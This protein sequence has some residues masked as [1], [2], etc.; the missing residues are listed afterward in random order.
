MKRDYIGEYRILD[1]LGHGGMG[2]VYK[3]IDERLKRTVAIKVIH[4]IYKKF[5]VREAI[6]LGQLDHPN[7]V[8]VYYAGDVD[9]D[10]FIVMEYVEG[11]TLDH[12]GVIPLSTCISYLKQTLDAVEYAHGKGIIHRDIK[13]SN[14]MV[15]SDGV[16]KV[17]DFGL[18]RV[19]LDGNQTITSGIVAGT[20]MYMSPE[21]VRGLSTLDHRTDIYSLGKT[22]YALVAGRLP[23]KTGNSSQYEIQRQIVEGNFKP[24]STFNAALPAEV[25][26]L[27][28]K[29]IATEPSHRYQSV[30]E[31]KEALL[32]LEKKLELHKSSKKRWV[33]KIASTPTAKLVLSVLIVVCICVGA[34]WIWSNNSESTEPVGAEK[35][36]LVLRVTPFADSI[37]VDGDLLR[38]VPGDT[39]LLEPGEHRIEMYAGGFHTRDTVVT[40]TAGSIKTI[41]AALA[42]L[43]QQEI[44]EM[45]VIRTSPASATVTIDG[46]VVGQSPVDIL[47]P[48][49]GTHT[50]VVNK[51]GFFSERRTVRVLENSP[52]PALDIVLRQQAFL[53]ITSTP[54]GANVYTQGSLLGTTP[55]NKLPVVAGKIDL[56]IQKEPF[57]ALDTALSFV[58]GR[59]T[60]L[61]VLLRQ[62]SGPIQVLVRPQ[63]SLYVNGVFTKELTLPVFQLI[64]LPFGSYEITARNPSSGAALTRNVLHDTA[65]KRIEFDL[66]VETEVFVNA[67]LTTADVLANG[68]KVG[69]TLQPILLLPGQY[70][71]RVEKPN[72]TSSPESELLVLTGDSPERHIVAFTLSCN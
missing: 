43:E 44:D 58:V 13:P 50:I 16:V 21:Q 6:A 52:L 62:A 32:K 35:T 3:A 68:K 66:S 42:R 38:T 63:G 10:V 11:S 5:S 46:L 48:A 20:P 2:T 17:M 60:V 1:E 30:L 8:H 19:E 64:E 57:A 70:V 22:F 39:V 9:N 51:E 56:S 29:A 71:I 37:Y 25:D 33:G 40:L 72:C 53:S 67:G 23:F 61:D 31:M 14:I 47:R 24:P 36:G 7:I 55:I 26:R 34:Y 28:M 18:A 4:S 15:R 45:L 65:N 27:I 54:S 59:T 69:Q 12:V 41:N 49:I